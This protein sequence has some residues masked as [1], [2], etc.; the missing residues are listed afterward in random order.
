MLILH[1]TTVAV[2]KAVHFQLIQIYVNKC[3]NQN[4]ITSTIS[5]CYRYTTDWADIVHWFIPNF[6]LKTIK[7]ITRYQFNDKNADSGKSRTRTV[8]KLARYS[9][10]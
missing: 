9:A 3:E 5:L 4:I 10:N 8:R 2:I 1:D 7:K 6:Q